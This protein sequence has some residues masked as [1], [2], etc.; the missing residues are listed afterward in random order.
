MIDRHHYKNHKLCSSA[1]NMDTYKWLDG[2]NSQVCE[3]RNNQLRKMA[4]SLAHMS[5]KNYIRNCHTRA[6]SW[7]LSSAEN[8]LSSSLQDG[9]TK[10]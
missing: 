1:Y 8:L 7:S 6:P 3:Q 2:V 9:A 10:W 5:F 4:K